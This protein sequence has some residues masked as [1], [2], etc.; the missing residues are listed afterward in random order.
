MVS[1]GAR[2]YPGAWVDVC[3][4]GTRN[5][6]SRGEM[7]NQ[8]ARSFTPPRQPPNGAKRKTAVD[9]TAV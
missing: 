1:D 2:P 8:A 5:L 4:P 7:L 3:F 6:Q 9:E